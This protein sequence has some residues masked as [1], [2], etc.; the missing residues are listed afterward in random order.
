M[1]G[2]HG[3]FNREYRYDILTEDITPITEAHLQLYFGRL[4]CAQPI[5]PEQVSDFVRQAMAHAE[6]LEALGDCVRD[7]VLP[8]K[9]TR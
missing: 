2:Y 1:A 9:D 4:R 7:L 6:D 5:T 8:L 3:E